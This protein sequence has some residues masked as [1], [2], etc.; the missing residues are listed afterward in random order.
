MII[1]CSI[2]AAMLFVLVDAA[3]DTYVHQHGFFLD[4]LFNDSEKL[5]FRLLVAVSFLVFGLIINRVFKERLRI[6][7]ELIESRERYSSLVNST[8]D[9]IYVVDRDG[10]YL[11]MNDIYMKRLGIS[12]N[13]WEGRN[14]N[15]FHSRKAKAIF[16]VNIHRVFDSQISLHNEFKSEKDGNYYLETF[17]PVKNE[18][19]KTVAVT[20]ISK[21]INQ[22]K[23]MEERLRALT[24]TDELTGLLN[25]RGF[26]LMAKKQLKQAEREQRSIFL[27]SADLDNL[28]IINDKYGHSEGDWVLMEIANV[29]EKC[30]RESDIIARLGGDEFVLL[31]NDYPGTDMESL[32]VR[33]EERIDMLNAQS[34]KPYKLSISMGIAQNETNRNTSL[35]ELISRA[36]KRMYEA[37]KKKKKLQK[38]ITQS[39]LHYLSGH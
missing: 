5:Y 32:S 22:R 14:F 7:K 30:Y 10:K 35:N 36:D 4:M 13:Q 19:G 21:E 38:Q 24:I 29:L 26:F 25:R 17:S 1:I 34:V 23:Q 11:F 8:N 20:I 9:S 31:V 39:V 37:K 16:F 2:L 3:V 12:G 18:C 27:I 28:K 15:E 6:E 33:L